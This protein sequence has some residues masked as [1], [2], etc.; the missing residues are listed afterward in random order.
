[1]GKQDSIVL[2]NIGDNIKNLPAVDKMEMVDFLFSQLNERRLR[3][4]LRMT[5]I[6]HSSLL[7]ENWFN[8]VLSLKSE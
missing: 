6:F 7:N 4:F 3:H 8:M 2:Y 1:M 5:N